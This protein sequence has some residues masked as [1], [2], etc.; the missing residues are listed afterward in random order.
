MGDHVK[1][2][3]NQITDYIYLGTNYCCQMHFDEELLKKGVTAD[4]SLEG[5]RM[6]KADGVEYFLWLP[7][8]DHTAPSIDALALGVQML[9][10][11]EKRK[12]KVYVHCK[13]GH[14]RAPSLIAAYFMSQGMSA[15]KAIRTIAKKRPEIHI[16]P[17][18]EAMIKKFAQEMKW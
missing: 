5:E 15:G 7:T 2:N 13:N 14:G 6:D 9:H 16:E 4:I 12:I 17:V 1:F 8:I 10:F 3:Y 11:C 18:Q